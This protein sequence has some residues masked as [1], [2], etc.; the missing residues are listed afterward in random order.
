MS[1]VTQLAVQTF[2]VKVVALF[3]VFPAFEHEITEQ[4][5]FICSIRN[6]S[7]PVL[8]AVTARRGVVRSDFLL[9]SK[10]RDQSVHRLRWTKACQEE[11]PK[12][13]GHTLYSSLE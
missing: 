9:Q 7:S 13:R 4:I 8:S 3:R 11:E 12:V 1:G 5:I 10:Q 6:N 2:E